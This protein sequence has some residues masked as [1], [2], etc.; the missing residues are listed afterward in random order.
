MKEA[1]KDDIEQNLKALLAK[2]MQVAADAIDD[3][4]ST[5]TLANWDS[6]RHMKLIVAL[7]EEYAL[8]FDEEQIVEMTAYPKIV[9]IVRQELSRKSG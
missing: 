5:A 9:A 7:E 6:L 2:I 3:K 1:M 4:A 8:A